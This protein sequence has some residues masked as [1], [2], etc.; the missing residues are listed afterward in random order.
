[1]LKI[2]VTSKNISVKLECDVHIFAMTKVKDLCVYVTHKHK[3]LIS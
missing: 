3:Y 2:I 1:M